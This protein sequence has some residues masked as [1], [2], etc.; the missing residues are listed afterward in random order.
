MKLYTILFFTSVNLYSQTTKPLNYFPVWSYH[1]DSINIHGVSLGLWT[2]YNQNRT[3]NTNGIK[4]ELLGVGI[5]MPLSPPISDYENIDSN[6]LKLSKRP[7]S[8][9]INGL[10]LSVTGTNCHCKTNGISTGFI[11]QYNYQVNGISSTLILNYTQIQN[12]LMASLFND[13]YKMNGVQIG[14]SNYGHKTIGIQLGIIS[15]SSNEMRGVQIGLFNTAMHLKGIQIGLWN[16]NQKR[17]LPFI[18]WNF[19]D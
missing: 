12:G 17:K 1:Q 5:G 18:N 10:N 2:L 14:A 16:V 7:L 6:A 3:T 9:K 13:A 19:K 15:N 11:G 4:F 8:E